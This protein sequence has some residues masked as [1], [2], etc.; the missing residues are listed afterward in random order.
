MRGSLESIGFTNALLT[1]LNA[2]EA[3]ATGD[4]TAAEIKALIGDASETNKGI[5][6]VATTPNTTGGSNDV[7]A[8]TPLKLKERL[9]TFVRNATSTIR[10]FV[11][12]ATNSE[13]QAGTDTSRAVTPAG[14]ASRIATTSRRG[15]IEL[16]TQAEVDSGNDTDR[17]VTPARLQAKLQ[18]GA[19]TSLATS[20]ITA[21][22]ITVGWTPPSSGFVGG[23]TVEWRTGGAAYETATV[24]ADTTEFTITGLDRGEDY[25]IRVRTTGVVA[26]SYATTTASTLNV[27]S[28]TF[29]IGT[30]TRA[31]STQLGWE[32]ESLG[33]INADLIAG[34]GDAFLRYFFLHSG[35]NSLRLWTFSTDSGTG[36]GA[37]PEL[38][39]GWETY[40]EAIV[41]EAGGLSL[42]LE[43][44]NHS[45]NSGQDAS[46]PYSWNPSTSKR[47]EIGTFITAWNALTDAQK[48]A[49]TL[50]L[51]FEP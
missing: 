18:S 41:V 20:D 46:E 15:L 7:K 28:Q 22:E 39:S 38:V 31:F 4:L 45:N 10:G 48:A 29:V 36:S 34:S 3:G 12:L 24:L 35:S 30:P 42:T 23:Y 21:S 5:L 40:A 6:Q 47:A 19:P 26:S 27:I 33:Q 49:T 13:V 43:G 8:V 16:A 25:D 32:G 9:A 14:L 1:K 2:V 44:P 37:G 17:A 11:E 51:Q 50:T